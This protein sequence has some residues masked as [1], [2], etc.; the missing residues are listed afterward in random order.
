MQH[1]H[2]DKTVKQAKRRADKKRNSFVVI[3]RFLLMGPLP[4]LALLLTAC[5]QMTSQA[6]DAS[7]VSGHTSPSGQKLAQI[8]AQV[9]SLVNGQLAQQ[10][11]T[12]DVLVALDNQVAL[13]KGYGLADDTNQIPNDPDTR[14]FLGSVTKEFTAT[15]ILLLQQEGKLHVQDLLCTYIPNCPSPWQAITL[16][17]VLTHTSGIPQPDDSQLSGDSPDAWIASFD[18]LP[19]EFTPGDQYDYCSTCYQ[20]LAY[21]VQQVSNEP[22]T[23]YVQQKILQPL[24]MTHS[25]F[26]AD[27]YYSQPEHAI[28]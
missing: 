18:A 3:A 8:A 28:G 11:F 19:L 1:N 25:G 26:D 6:Q 2:L 12:G 27:A 21:V 23:Q 15:A 5:G 7:S 13:V 10:M 20:I 14:F 16:K 24:K 9:D 22:Y 4:F 17:E